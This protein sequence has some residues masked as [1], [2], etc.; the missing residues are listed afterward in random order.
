MMD[1]RRAAGRERRIQEDELNITPI[2]NIFLILVPF[3]LLT[4]VFVRIAI[5]E[6]S[7]PNADQ[8]KTVKAQIPPVVTILSITEAGFELKTQ[9]KSR[10]ASI[11]RNQDGF[12]Y[13]G[14][15]EQLSAVKRLHPQTEDIILAPALSITYE[16]IIKVM[17]SCRENGFLNISI[18]A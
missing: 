1:L 13:R 7:L 9:E 12:D 14:L 5:L 16:T 17:D 10:F 3:L 8:V 18:S 11:P 4:A 15:V 2:M 6:F